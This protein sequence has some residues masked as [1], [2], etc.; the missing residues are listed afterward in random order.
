MA[1]LTS[2]NGAQRTNEIASPP[3]KLDVTLNKGKIRRL[4]DS[5]S[6]DAADELGTSGLI[7][8]MT[9]PAGARVVDARFVAPASG[10]TGLVDIG[11][12][13]SADGVEAADANGFFNQADPG[14]A[15]VDAKMGATL[16]GWNKKFSSPV[17]VQIDVTEITADSGGDTWHLEIFYVLE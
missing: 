17:L 1:T 14:A 12:A 6:I 4:Y 16:P 11:W 5:Y 13:A 10:A 8:M 3:V 7:S 2:V 9:I 15:A